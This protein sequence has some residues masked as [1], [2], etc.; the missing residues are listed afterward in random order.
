VRDFTDEEQEL[1][2][3]Q[4]AEGADANPGCTVHGDEFT[5]EQWRA[6]GGCPACEDEEGG[7]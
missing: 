1:I 3:E 6:A 7:N 4:R 2:R 5:D